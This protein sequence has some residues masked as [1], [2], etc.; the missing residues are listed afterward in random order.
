MEEPGCPEKEHR[1]DCKFVHQTLLIEWKLFQ[2]HQGDVILIGVGVVPLFESV[3]DLDIIE[4]WLVP[5]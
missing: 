2:L 1:A 3:G 5:V 4:G